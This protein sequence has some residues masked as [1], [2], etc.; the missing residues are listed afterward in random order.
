MPEDIQKNLNINTP[1][2][3][4][5]D[6]TLEAN[7]TEII[8][9]LDNLHVTNIKGLK[10]LSSEGWRLIENHIPA[11]VNK[12]RTEIDKLR[13]DTLGSGTKEDERSKSELLNDWNKVKL[14]LYYEYKSEKCP[15]SIVKRKYED[16]A[17]IDADAFDLGIQELKDDKSFD[18]GTKIDEI[19]EA[20]KVYTL[21]QKDDDKK[22]LRKKSHGMLFYG[23]PGTG[24]T[25]VRPYLS[26]NM[27]YQP[28]LI[29][30]GRSRIFAPL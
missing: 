20:I 16:F 8:K 21:T 27:K 10:E 26:I 22:K 5:L 25:E 18:M 14:L 13:T 15:N 2:D 30:G 17:Y 19:R 7:T 1:L 4:F 3:K 29:L 24:K 11:Y 28:R 9:I 23:P 12:L 6:Q